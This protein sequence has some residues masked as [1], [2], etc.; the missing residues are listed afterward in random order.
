MYTSNCGSVSKGGGA[1]AGGSSSCWSMK[2]KPTRSLIEE[3]GVDTQRMTDV[4]LDG[5]ENVS[6]CDARLEICLF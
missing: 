4:S 3:F 1:G 5:P 2:L 6:S